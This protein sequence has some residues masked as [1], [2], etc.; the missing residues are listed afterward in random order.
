MDA[1][2]APVETIHI[3]DIDFHLP[4][5]NQESLLNKIKLKLGS[6]RTGVDEDIFGWNSII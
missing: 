1:V 2:V 6:I 3:N 4:S 5:Y